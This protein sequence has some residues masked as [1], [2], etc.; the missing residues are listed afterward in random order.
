[1]KKKLKNCAVKGFE[2]LAE[3]NFK[4]ITE[5]VSKKLPWKAKKSSSIGI[6]E[7]N[8][9]AEESKDIQMHSTENLPNQSPKEI[10]KALPNQF[11]KELAK[12]F[13]EECRINS[14]SNQQR[15]FQRNYQRKSERN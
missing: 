13:P 9:I 1:M 8:R 12:K 15:I 5:V 10:S 14:Q 6:V 11:P 2:R 7:S 4:R 3:L